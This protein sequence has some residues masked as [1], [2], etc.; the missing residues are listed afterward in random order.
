M[1]GRFD[2]RRGFEVATG[3][4]DGDLCDDGLGG[5]WMFLHFPSLL[6]QQLTQHVPSFTQEQLMH[7]PSLLH[8]QHAIEVASCWWI[9][10]PIP[11]SK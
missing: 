1:A 7:F 9:P 4:D 8:L 11:Q 2:D 5:C 3:V 6:G 10:G